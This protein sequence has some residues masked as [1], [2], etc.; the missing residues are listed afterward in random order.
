MSLPMRSQADAPPALSRLPTRGADAD[1]YSPA[2]INSRELPFPVSTV[3]PK[4]G[5]SHRRNSE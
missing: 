4:S 1:R 2:A 5:F 3:A